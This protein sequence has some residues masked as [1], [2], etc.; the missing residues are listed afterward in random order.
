MANQL[1]ALWDESNALDLFQSGFRPCHGT[2][3]ALVT[4]L[5]YLLR[6]ADKGKMSL[7]FLLDISADFDTVDHDILQF[8]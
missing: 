7:L 1:Q 8:S 2:E 4:L 6:E 5:D 3:I